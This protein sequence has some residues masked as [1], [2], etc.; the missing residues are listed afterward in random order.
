M[1]LQQ[2]SSMQNINFS[3][4]TQTIKFV[5][6]FERSNITFKEDDIQRWMSWDGPGYEQM[7]EQGI[8]ALI[9][10]DNEK[11][12]DEDEIGVSQP[13]KCPFSH[14]EA[15]QKM[16]NYFL[17]TRT[18]QT[19]VLLKSIKYSNFKLITLVL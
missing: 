16:D 5:Q 1:P 13:S 11:E 17:P 6:Q 18:K 12:A 2:S 7:D 8:V 15:M 3:E 19:L 14:A 10:E 4:K 9:T